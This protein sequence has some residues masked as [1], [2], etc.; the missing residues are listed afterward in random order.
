MIEQGVLHLGH[1]MMQ[2]AAPRR[3]GSPCGGPGHPTRTH[4]DGYLG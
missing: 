1:R 4:E 3:G 2:V